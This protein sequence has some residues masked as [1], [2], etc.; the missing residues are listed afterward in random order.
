M[1]KFSLFSVPSLH[2]ELS[3]AKKK[4][5]EELIDYAGTKYPR[6]L[7]VR[8]YDVVYQIF[9]TCHVISAKL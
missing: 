9:N 4:T 2:L 1:V 8:M 3:Q 7:S 6:S 5:G